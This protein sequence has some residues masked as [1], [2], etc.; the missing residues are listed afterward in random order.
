[1]RGRAPGIQQGELLFGNFQEK[2]RRLAEAVA[3]EP[4]VERVGQIVLPLRPGEP[5][6]AKP[7]LLL[8]FLRVVHGLHVGEDPFLHPG[9]EDHGELE[10]LG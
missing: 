6:V 7:A 10:S 2:A 1:M 8:Q 4:P 3:V 5:H 9:E